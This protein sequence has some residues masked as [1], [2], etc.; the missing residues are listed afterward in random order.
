MLARRTL[1][2][3]E[4]EVIKTWS[5]DSAGVTRPGGAG[6]GM[7]GRRQEDFQGR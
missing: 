3:G 1:S 6:K 7:L 2:R 4:D 5:T